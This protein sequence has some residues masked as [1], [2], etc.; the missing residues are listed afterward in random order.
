MSVERGYFLNGKQRS[1]S[2][3]PVMD[4]ADRVFTLRFVASDCYS[5]ACHSLRYHAPV[6][7]Y[8]KVDQTA[9]NGSHGEPADDS[10]CSRRVGRDRQLIGIENIRRPFGS[11][12]QPFV[13]GSVVDG[14]RIDAEMV[15][16]GIL[17]SQVDPA[18]VGWH[19]VDFAQCIEE[20]HAPGRERH[21][22]A[23]RRTILRLIPPS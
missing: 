20:D 23:D 1:G 6:G 21:V 13:R 2:Q 14:N 16:K 18:P 4:V 8:V 9:V 22:P 7:E 3:H 12:P 19:A 17:D 10:H 15:V 5:K 11:R